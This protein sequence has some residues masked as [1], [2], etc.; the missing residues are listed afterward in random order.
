MKS[1]AT[2]SVDARRRPR[3][4]PH[5]ST[6]AHDVRDVHDANRRGARRFRLQVR[7][8]LARARASENATR[9]E[10]RARWIVRVAIA[11]RC[12]DVRRDAARA[13][14][15]RRR[16][17]TDERARSFRF[18]EPAGRRRR[19]AARRS[20]ARRA[21]PRCV[22]RYASVSW[23]RG[24]SRRARR[25]RATDDEEKCL[26]RRRNPRRRRRRRSDRRE[27]R[28]CARGDL[29]RRRARGIADDGDRSGRER[30]VGERRTVTDDVCARCAVCEWT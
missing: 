7:R 14:T 23:M 1:N 29:S 26:G 9:R 30:R 11:A 17:V 27:A 15:R 13:A 19:S 25:R 3:A 2:R 22:S 4:R 21:T 20:S 12:D 8:D 10:D 24:R 5:T 6:H 16:A 18:F 28:R